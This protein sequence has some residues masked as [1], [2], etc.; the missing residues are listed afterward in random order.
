MADYT[1]G[2]G[3]TGTL[4]IRDDGYNLWAIIKNTGS[5]TFANGKSWSVQVG[6]GSASGTF[7]ISGAQEV[8][9]WQG[10]TDSSLYMQL[11]M[12]ATG[13]SGLGGPS[14]VGANIFRATAPG[15][16]VG[17]AWSN[18]GVTT[19]QINFGGPGSDGGAGI[20]FYLV[21]YGKSNPPENGAYVEFTTG[22]GANP[23][24]GLDPGATY[25]ARVYAHNRV[26]YS[27][28]SAV[29]GATTLA[30]A[31]IKIGGTYRYAVPYIKVAG[32]YR[33]ALPF[34]KS[35]GVYRRT[36]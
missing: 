27:A 34:V 4:I 6:G 29:S 32:V 14:S 23:R 22:T 1:V 31:R 21:R 30:P 16:P 20:D 25:Y 18:I 24:T 2:T 12:G 8:V 33:M 17:Y 36:G 7:S 35:G 11:N 15:A 28:P 10:A 3:T 13:T 5:Q 26:G 19:A 9:V